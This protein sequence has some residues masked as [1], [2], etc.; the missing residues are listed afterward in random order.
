MKPPSDQPP[1]FPWLDLFRLVAA[2][3]VV[4][5]HARGAAMGAFGALPAETKTAAAAAFYLVTR[6]GNEAVVAFF[7]LSG[8]FVGGMATER[9][10]RGDFRVADYAIDRFARIMVPLVPALLLTAFVLYV[11]G[12]A[13]NLYE[14]AG[15][16]LSL[17]GIVVDSYGGNAPLWSLAYEAWFYLLAGIIGALAM[18]R[19]W[20]APLAAAL[21]LT[22]LVFTKLSPIYL[23]CWLL[24]TAAYL[25][26]P[27]RA[28]SIYVLSAALLI[29]YSVAC[30]QLQA[31][32]VS[33]ST[34]MVSR[35]RQWIPTAEVGRLLLSAGFALLIQ[36]L[37]LHEPQRAWTRGIDAMGS[38]GAAFSYSLYL[39]HYPII[40]LAVFAGLPQSPTLDARAFGGFGFLILCCIAAATV[41]YWL[42]ERHTGA[43]RR[44]LKTVL[45]GRGHRGG[46]VV[47][48]LDP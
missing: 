31:D 30:I 48:G 24:G 18:R 16:L 20:S 45:L 28:Q 7:V 17:Q 14:L 5:V 15:N 1:R 36:Q 33:V 10:L 43:V 44:W 46:A 27:R 40:Q 2:M 34:D 41:N 32:T 8:F 4:I 3:T 13:L 11:Q 35:A 37:V 9:I 26:R 25:H 42:F 21:L 6:V 19:R 12:K 23:F 22:V 29:I 38:R 47:P 39:T